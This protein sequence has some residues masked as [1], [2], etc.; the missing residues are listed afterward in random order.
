MVASLVVKHKPW[1]LQASVVTARGLSSGSSQILEHRL[2]NCG[3]WATGMQV[4]CGSPR[5]RSSQNRDGARVSCT[6]T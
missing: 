3:A 2:N 5:V 4:A 6:G 1:G